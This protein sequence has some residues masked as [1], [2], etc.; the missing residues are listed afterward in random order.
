M[1]NELEIWEGKYMIR[2]TETD[3]DSEYSK[4]RGE[5]HKPAVRIE[6]FELRQRE[7]MDIKNPTGKE[8]E[9]KKQVDS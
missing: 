4:G 8:S 9:E 1:V 7:I 3:R 6:V 2:V 5:P